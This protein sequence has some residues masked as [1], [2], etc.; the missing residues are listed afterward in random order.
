MLTS[1]GVMET[2]GVTDMVLIGNSTTETKLA[3]DLLQE[4]LSVMPISLKRMVS[5]SR[6][7]NGPQMSQLFITKVK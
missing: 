1:C 2:A 7:I 5:H 6:V 4:Q 3:I